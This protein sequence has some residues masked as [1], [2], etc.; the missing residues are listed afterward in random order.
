M[1]TTSPDIGEWGDEGVGG[2]RGDKGVGGD[3]EEISPPTPPTPLPFPRISS[4]KLTPIIPDR[5][6]VMIAIAQNHA[7]FIAPAS[8]AK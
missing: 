7:S 8:T 6:I 1:S 2:V 3:E 5:E 4:Q